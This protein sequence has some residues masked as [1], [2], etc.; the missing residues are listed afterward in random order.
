MF[1]RV[2]Q[3][4]AIVEA[5]GKVT[6]IAIGV[7]RCVLYIHVDTAQALVN[8]PLLVHISLSLSFHEL[9]QHMDA[10]ARPS[11]T[12]LPYSSFD[13]ISYPHSFTFPPLSTRGSGVFT[14]L[15]YPI[16]S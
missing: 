15:K 13:L 14:S 1:G 10:Q 7:M 6:T 2:V 3:G 8:L 12:L 16:L 9:A 4:F 11:P 5:C